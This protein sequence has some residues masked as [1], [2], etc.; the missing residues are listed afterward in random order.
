MKQDNIRVVGIRR[1][2]PD[3]KALARIF[4]ELAQEQAKQE[5]A[6]KRPVRTKPSAKRPGPSR[7]TK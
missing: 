5:T 4:I 6:A 2:H 1:E 7:R 3:L